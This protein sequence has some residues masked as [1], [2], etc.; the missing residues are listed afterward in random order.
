ME[1]QGRGAMH[2]IW[3]WKGLKGAGHGASSSST[4]IP[5]LECKRGRNTQTPLSTPTT[6]KPGACSIFRR[7]LKG[8]NPKHAAAFHGQVGDRTSPVYQ[9]KRTTAEEVL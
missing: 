6:P 4:T 8:P 2:E 5:R 7:H 9:G 1:I 3:G